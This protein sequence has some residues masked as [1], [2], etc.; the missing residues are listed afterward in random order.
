MRIL[1]VDDSTMKNEWIRRIL[2][3][4]N[5]Q[6]DEI[7][8][9]N[10]ASRMIFDNPESYNGIILDMQFPILLD[11]GVETRTGETLLKKLKHKGVNIPVL[12][13]STMEFR[14]AEKYPFFKGNTYGFHNS[15]VLNQ[16]LEI[17]KDGE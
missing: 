14:D 15:E 6:Y 3:K 5:V 11:G 12:G 1:I 2:N 13:N 10:G 9:F 7:T 4:E 8:Y 17:I 16:F